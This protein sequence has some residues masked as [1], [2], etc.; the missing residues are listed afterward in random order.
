MQLHQV[1]LNMRYSSGDLTMPV[2]DVASSLPLI[3]AC[4][5]DEE[6]EIAVARLLASPISAAIFVETTA[7]EQIG[8]AYSWS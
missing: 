6:D 2:P 5:I 1:R 7:T 3:Q 8:V 4:T